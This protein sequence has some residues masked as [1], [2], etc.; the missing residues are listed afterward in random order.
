MWVARTS[1]PDII[2]E[3][4]ATTRIPVIAKA[5]IG[6]DDEAR[7]LQSLGVDMIDETEVLTPADPF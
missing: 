2:K 4:I 3:I 5:R 1:H 6:H 7:V